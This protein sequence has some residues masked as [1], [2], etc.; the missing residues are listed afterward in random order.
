MVY[1]WY[2]STRTL[3]TAVILYGVTLLIF[4]TAFFT[5]YWLQSH[6]DENLPNPK[7]TNLGKKKKIIFNSR[8]SFT[9]RINIF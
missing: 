1:E 7:F 8:L 4:I 5:P 3:K 6:A 9:D 2:D